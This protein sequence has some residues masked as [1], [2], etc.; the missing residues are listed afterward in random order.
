MPGGGLD[1]RGWVEYCARMA[2]KRGN[3]DRVLG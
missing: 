2:C 1:D 3:R